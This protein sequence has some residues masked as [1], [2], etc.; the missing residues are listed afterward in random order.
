VTAPTVVLTQAPAVAARYGRAWMDGLRH[1]AVVEVS[2][3]SR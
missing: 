3:A 2:T 1:F